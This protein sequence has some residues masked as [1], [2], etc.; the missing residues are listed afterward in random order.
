MIDDIN[1]G[2]YKT[3]AKSQKIKNTHSHLPGNSAEYPQHPE[4]QAG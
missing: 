3:Q 2:S 1:N 4:N